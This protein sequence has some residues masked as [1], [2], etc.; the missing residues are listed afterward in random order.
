MPDRGTTDTIFIIRQ[1]REKNAL[2][3]TNPC[4]LFSLTLRIARKV[5]W[6]I[7][8]KLGVEEWLVN[9]VQAMD[10][11]ARNWVHIGE[12]YS[13]KFDVNVGVHKG[14]VLSSLLFIIVLEAL[15]RKF[16]AGC[17]WVLLCMDDLAMAD[18]S[19]DD[20]VERIMTC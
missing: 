18:I 1:L 11:N 17:P 9:T 7:M 14:S 8:R 5:I 20:L 3:P 10:S 19:L 4:I 2:Q 15:S 12:G 6:W 13:V 16:H